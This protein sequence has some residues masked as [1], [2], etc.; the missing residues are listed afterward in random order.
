MGSNNLT[1]IRI[2]T[3]IARDARMDSYISHFREILAK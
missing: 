3:I 2:E 1:A